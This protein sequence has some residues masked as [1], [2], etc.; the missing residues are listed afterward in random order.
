MLHYLPGCDVRKNHP[1]AIKKLTNYMK[2]QGAKI[3]ACCR[4]KE[5]LSA[6]EDTIINNCTMCDFILRETHPETTVMSLYE[7]VLKDNHFPWIDHH[8]QKITVQDCLRTKDNKNMLDAIRTCLEK[9][10]F[11]V[12][13]LA[14]NF[15]KARFDGLWIYNPPMDICLDLAPITMKK[16]TDTYFEIIDK[17]EQEK[18]MQS[19]VQQYQTDKVLTYCNGCERGMKFGGITPIHLVELLSEGL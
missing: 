10:N 9:M 5:Q 4:T 15:E 18:R 11:E 6:K 1:E 16:F 13:E 17:D 2:E 14:E 8:G 12:V 7:Y 3:E 19:S